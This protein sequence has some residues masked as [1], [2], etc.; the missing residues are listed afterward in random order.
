MVG[1]MV[2]AATEGGSSA[3]SHEVVTNAAT[4]NRNPTR[5]RLPASS[6]DVVL[7]FFIPSAP[8]CPTLIRVRD[9]VADQ[10]LPF[11][12]NRADFSYLFPIFSGYTT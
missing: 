2:G 10:Y 4:R 11:H 1:A 12:G 6:D 5:T 9:I 7:F 8:F 3:W